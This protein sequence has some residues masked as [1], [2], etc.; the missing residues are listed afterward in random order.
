MTYKVLKESSV[1]N[2][3]RPSTRNGEALSHQVPLQDFTFFVLIKL[4][5]LYHRILL[6]QLSWPLCVRKCVKGLKVGL[7][8]NMQLLK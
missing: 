3:L 4:R 2:V 6:W 8:E 1:C 7:I 5:K